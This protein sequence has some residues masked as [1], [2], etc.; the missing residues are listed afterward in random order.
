MARLQTTLALLKGECEYSFSGD[1]CLE[2][3]ERF[4]TAAIRAMDDY[5][6]AV[7]QLLE[8]CVPDGLQTTA[9]PPQREITAL[10]AV[11][12]ARRQS[13]VGEMPPGRVSITASLTDAGELRLAFHTM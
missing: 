13:N 10:V 5:L 1:L 11:G 3:E 2:C 6:D 4:Q 12:E 8:R 9:I 7:E